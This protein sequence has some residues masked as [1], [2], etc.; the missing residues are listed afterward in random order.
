[1]Q[2]HS[3]THAFLWTWQR[4]VWPAKDLGPQPVPHLIPSKFLLYVLN[5]LL[6]CTAVL[7][8]PLW[9]SGEIPKPQQ[10][11]EKPGAG[12]DAVNPLPVTLVPLPLQSQR[13]KSAPGSMLCAGA[14]SFWPTVLYVGSVRGLGV[15]VAVA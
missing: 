4:D 11:F 12:K 3:C 1:M 7:M 8:Q 10:P 6:A 13:S 5:G 2:A 9:L 14:P 15:A